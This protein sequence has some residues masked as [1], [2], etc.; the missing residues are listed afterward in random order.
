MPLVYE[1]PFWDKCQWNRFVFAEKSTE[2]AIEKGQEKISSF[3]L[4]AMEV[5]HRLYS[6]YDVVELAAIKPE[7]Q[8]A[9]TLHD[10]LTEHSEFAELVDSVAGNHYLS[11]LATSVFIRE[12][13]EKLPTPQNELKDPQELHE[14]VL[15]LKRNATGS[16][17]ERQLIQQLIQEGREA[18]SAVQEW[19]DQVERVCEETVA[20]ALG[21]AEDEV[22]DMQDAF[23]ALGWG[24]EGSTGAQAGS[25]EDKIK[26]AQMLSREDKLKQII[27]QA[28]GLKR[29]AARKQS[30]KMTGARNSIESVET[31]RDLARVLPNELLALREPALAPLFAKKFVDSQLLQYKMGGKEQTTQGP[32]VVCID[33]SGSMAGDEE[34]WA[35][36]VMLAVLGIATTQKRHFRVIHYSSNVTRVDDFKPKER[37]NKKLLATL[38]HFPS[39]GT[40]WQH[41]LDSAV[42]CI[43]GEKNYKKA[44]I[45]LIT[46]GYCDVCPEWLE[47]FQK[48]QQELGFTLYGIQ[49]G[50][51]TGAM[52]QL[53]IADKHYIYI[54]NLKQDKAIEQVLAI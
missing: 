8:W 11:G 54:A 37:D 4:F 51:D 44:D 1:I 43:K 13:A 39:G 50:G 25:I 46:D 36:A 40:D 17:Q 33:G 24:L 32:I 10:A 42:Q 7:N 45:V 29:I 26:L 48:Q 47:Q 19:K 12:L 49:I 20:A 5:F 15:S 9:K 3:G 35:K 2:A 14:Q 34:I 28:G 21:K 31:G 27:K 18:I 6:P 22:S 53:Q 16:M 38:A 41:P 23:S 30:T 52:S